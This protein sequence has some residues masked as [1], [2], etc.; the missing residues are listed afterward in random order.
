MKNFDHT[1]KVESNIPMPPK[2]RYPWIDMGVGDSFLAKDTTLKR[3]CSAACNAGKRLNKKF[4]V[5]A[6]DGGF[7]VWR[8][9]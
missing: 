3:I 6:V 8:M 9:R 5:A 1:A 2:P 4:R 7:R